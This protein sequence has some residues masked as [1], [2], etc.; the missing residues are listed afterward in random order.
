MSIS[1]SD[2]RPASYALVSS[3][4]VSFFEWEYTFS[5]TLE[6]QGTGDAEN[7]LAHLDGYPANVTAVTYSGGGSDLDFG[8]VAAGSSQTSSNTFTVRVNRRVRTPD[9]DLSW[10]INYDDPSGGGTVD[11][12]LPY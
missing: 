10:E 3:R 5:F 6:N 4:R 12:T 1:I 8:T 11:L 7:V 2:L 9:R